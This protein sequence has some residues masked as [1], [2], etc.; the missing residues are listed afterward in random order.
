MQFSPHVF[1]F[2]KKEE[3]R[4]GLVTVMLEDLIV[5]L[6]RGFKVFEA[7]AR[8]SSGENPSVH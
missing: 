1:T 6:K 5:K 8:K 2:T 7:F 3:R 4:K